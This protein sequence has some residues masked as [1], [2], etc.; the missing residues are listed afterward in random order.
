MSAAG[1]AWAGADDE[2]PLHGGA[3]VGGASCFGKVHPMSQLADVFSGN[4]F[5]QTQGRGATA[6]DRMPPHS[7]D[8]EM[9][10]LASMTLDR[11]IV[12]EVVQRV[13]RD[14]FYLADHQIIFEAL[15]DLW[16][17]NRPIDAVIL[18]DELSKRQLLEEVGGTPYIAELLGSVP[19]AAH[20]MHYA[21][22]VREKALLRQL[23]DASN[24]CL[25]DA[26]A[27]HE[28]V[29]QVMDRAE[30]RIFDIAQKKVTGE[31]VSLGSVAEN[32]YE[33]LEDKG[34]AGLMT[35]FIDLD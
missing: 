11:D 13:E 21:N 35:D 12:G 10:L 24:K 6:F 27:P 17:A 23:I 16:Q 19:S 5:E 9:C 4:G 25:Q 31:I 34:R 14:S 8:A 28:T 32:V 26:Y 20:A 2:E 1:P 30:K 29:E 3:A 22:I 7:I 15:V 18:R 33:M